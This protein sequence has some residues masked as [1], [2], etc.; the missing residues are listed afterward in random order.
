VHVIDVSSAS[1]RDPVE[2]YEV[3]CRELERFEGTGEEGAPVRLADKPAI[4]AANKIDAL[5]DP[6]RLSRLRSHLERRAVPV[7]PVSAATG[8]GIPAL[9]EAMWRQ[10][11]AAV[12]SAA[13]SR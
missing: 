7:F 1:G 10:L 6:A 13:A 4:A 5:D 3:I 12:T 2:D 11:A 9:L 8:E